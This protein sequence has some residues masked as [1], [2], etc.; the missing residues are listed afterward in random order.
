MTL[1]DGNR[2]IETGLYKFGAILGDLVEVGSLRAQ[3]RC[4][5]GRNSTVYP[6]NSVRGVVPPDSIMKGRGNI[7]RKISM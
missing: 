3:P 1:R 5:V 7:V 6:L 4:I 2:I